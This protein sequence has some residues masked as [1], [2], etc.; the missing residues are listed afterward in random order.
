MQYKQLY[1]WARRDL[2]DA[3]LSLVA[4]HDKPRRRALWCPFF[5]P[6]SEEYFNLEWLNTK[7]FESNPVMLSNT[8]LFPLIDFSEYFMRNVKRGVGCW[9]AA[10]NCRLHEYFLDF[11][12]GDAVVERAAQVQA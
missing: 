2:G 1:Y 4:G 7:D 6:N 11:I 5:Y 8:F 12:A 3:Q 10:I 9:D